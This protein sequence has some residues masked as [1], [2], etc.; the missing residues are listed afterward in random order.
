VKNIGQ[1]LI[2]ISFI[3]ALI[4]AAATFT[5]L[6]SIKSTEV[7]SKKVTILV[8]ADTIPPR[9]LIDKKMVTELQVE[10]N[11]IF[12]DYIKNPADIIGKY[13]KETISKNEGFQVNKL[14]AENSGEELT[15]KVD[16]S[17]R[18][19]SISV[20]GDQGVSGLLKP[21]DFVDMV[22]YL[23]EKKDEKKVIIPEMAKIIMQNIEVLAVNKQLERE[24]KIEE[25]KQN[26]TSFLVTL[27]VPVDKVEKVVLAENIG[28]IKLAL[29]P[30]KNAET[31]ATQ[32]V[33]LDKLTLNGKLEKT[34][35]ALPEKDLV[36]NNKDKKNEEYVNY[37]VKE[38]DT[39]KS[40]SKD[41]YG[42]PDK[43]Q[44]IQKANNIY[45][46]DLI[47][48]GVILRIPDL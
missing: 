23:T 24:D 39:L 1:R 7:V 15:L 10:D 29:R 11:L 18:A 35:P 46:E 41:F 36:S 16:K 37:L 48:N 8:A 31:T 21:G 5:Y 44:V 27:A 30:L 13:S 47:I 4:A 45:N 33:T 25:A 34:I 20:S 28:T 12:Q 14:L 26:I 32:G 9:T 42:D 6:R 38:G 40:I 3:F 17:H 22:V 43:Y 2:L 19:I